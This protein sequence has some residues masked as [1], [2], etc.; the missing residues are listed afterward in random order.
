M[1]SRRICLALLLI[2]ALTAPALAQVPSVP[3]CVR[4][5]DDDKCEA[6]ATQYDGS[7]H[8]NDTAY[9]V[10]T[11]P[12][13]E[14]VFV[15]GES[16]AS[17]GSVDI[18][19]VAYSASTGTQ[20][21]TA[22]ETSP[23][24]DE[25]RTMAVTPDGR[26]VLVAGSTSQTAMELIAYD[27]ATGARQWLATHST[28]RSDR[29]MGLVLSRD[30]ATAFV[31]GYSSSAIAS[32]LGVEDYDFVTIAFDVA[33]GDERWTARYQG[34]A[35]FWDVA[36]AL[37]V[38]VVPGSDPPQEVVAVTGR[39]NVQG[40]GN[41]QTDMVTVAYDAAT[42][43]QLWE[44]RFDG[45]AHDRD[46][47]YALDIHGDAVYVTGESWGPLEDDYETIAYDLT[48][49]TERWSTRRAVAGSDRP[50]GILASDEAVYVTGHAECCLPNRILTVDAYDPETGALLWEEQR[51]GPLGEVGF[52]LALSPD[53]ETLYVGGMD[54]GHVIGTGFNIAQA[55]VNVYPNAGYALFLL[56]ALDT[57]TGNQRWA[58]LYEGGTFTGDIALTRDGSR[59]FITGGGQSS[60]S[61]DYSTAAY[62]L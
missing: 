48:T 55:G 47:P 4:P 17:S 18:T 57:E 8:A 16:Y 30:G 42:G 7:G 10:K 39:S 13:G 41:N 54:G 31:T 40:S 26:T 12:A 11:D 29:V 44:R 33:T 32:E 23:G 60:L 37:D 46:Y 36:S 19:T 9:A 50:L 28:G 15:V 56:L 5:G 61:G 45:P 53:G 1:L 6:W 38:G 59:I 27:A 51:T 52:R 35:R 62:A 49:G 2:V 14:R 20:L 25:G 58:A 22:S 43:G 21:W 34:E 24:Q 3:V